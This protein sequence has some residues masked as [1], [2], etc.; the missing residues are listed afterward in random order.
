V[1]DKGKHTV[2]ITGASAGVGRAVAH[3]FARE[4]WYLGLI[5]RDAAV[6][7]DVVGEVERLGGSALAAP[8]DVAEAEAVFKATEAVRARFGRIDVWV[9]DAMAT[10]FAPVWDVSPEEYRRVTEVTYL[11]VVHGTMAALL[12]MRPRNRGRIIQIGSALAYRGIPLQ[13]AY[14]GAK[15][16]IRGFSDSNDGAASGEYATVRRGA[17]AH[18]QTTL[19]GGSGG[20]A[21]GRRR[22]DLSRRAHAEAG[23]LDRW[24]HDQ[25]NPGQHGATRRCRPLSG[26]QDRRG[27]GN[28]I[29][30]GAVS[31]GQSYDF[32]RRPA[33]H[34]RPVR[35]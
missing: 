29:A 17:H 6:L 12:E 13:A 21:G 16:A 15:H 14:C 1:T 5:A 18:A 3:R 24:E 26:P 20:A 2:V 35:R 33:P 30:G 23:I 25:S 8:A 28:K 31:P 10:I 27:P 22:C 32:R 9:N 34:A 4:G 19:G 11:G 7:Q